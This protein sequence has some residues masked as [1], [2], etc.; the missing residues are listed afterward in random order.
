M[1]DDANIRGSC[2]HAVTPAGAQ[3]SKK[4][5]PEEYVTGSS[6]LKKKK[7]GEKKTELPSLN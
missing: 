7:H 6:I 4:G 3:L 2:V 1:M 5:I